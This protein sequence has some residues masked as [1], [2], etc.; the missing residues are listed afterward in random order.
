MGGLSVTRLETLGQTKPHFYK[1][2]GNWN[3]VFGYNHIVFTDPKATPQKLVAEAEK[4]GISLEHRNPSP[5][6][7]GKIT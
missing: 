6:P 7:W 2:H 5:I 1:R 4:L 3:F